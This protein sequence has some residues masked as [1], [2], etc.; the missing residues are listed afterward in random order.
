MMR[1][2]L[3]V[4][5]VLFAACEDPT[6]ATVGQRAYSMVTTGGNHT[7][8][9]ATTGQ[10]YCWGEGT[11]GEV[12]DGTLSNRTTPTLIDASAAFKSVSAGTEHTCALAVDASAF[13]WGSNEFFQLGSTGSAA[14][15]PRQVSGNLR[16][17]TIS[18]G[19][20]HTCAIGADSLAYCWGFNRYGQLGNGTLTSSGQPAA[21]SG[22]LKF[23]A[24]SA[25]VNHTCAITV[26][27]ILYCWG[28]NETGQLGLGTDAPNAAVPTIAK[29]PVPFITIDAGETHTCGVAQANRFYC[30]GSN[31][32]GELG[33]GAAFQAG[34]PA[35]TAPKV[36][37]LQYSYGRSIS[38]GPHVTCAIDLTYSNG[39]CWGRGE[40]GQLGN[41]ATSDQYIPQTIFM[42]PASRHGYDNLRF[43]M[44]SAHGAR[45]ACGIAD[46]SV[47][48][49][50]T[51]DFGQLGA[52]G[53]G[54]ANNP[55]RVAD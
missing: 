9:L 46:Q 55:V 19:G 38:A 49:W 43:T 52:I 39:A 51:G 7:C 5:C 2:R 34:L 41:G 10:V 45:H 31:E 48:C 27:G 1:L 13:C 28:S 18:A 36:L 23:R 12:G 14:A 17:A 29:S 54:F 4:L 37:V 32:H 53:A 20:S 42:Q 21:V 44:I 15:S 22:G 30:W 6:V 8:A 11:H 47:F 40:D 3:V 25:G 26:A 50:G 16:F 24:V 35:A 33:D